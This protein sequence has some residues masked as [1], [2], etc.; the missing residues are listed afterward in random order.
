MK[1]FSVNQVKDLRAE[2]YL[3]SLVLNTPPGGKLPGINSLVQGSGVGRIRLEHVLAKLCA[4]GKLEVRPSS[5]YYRRAVSDEDKRLVLIDFEYN[6][7]LP[8]GKRKNLTT[9]AS[10]LQ[11][12][13]AELSRLCRLNG[14]ELVF[15]SLGNKLSGVD[16]FFKNNRFV[17]GFIR[18]SCC[19]EVTELF[20]KYLCCVDLLPQNADTPYPTVLDSLEM[21][22]IQMDYLLRRGYRHIGYLHQTRDSRMF[23]QNKRLCDYYRVMAENGI[24]VEPNWVMYCGSDYE[25]FSQ[26]LYKVMNSKRPPEAFIVDGNT[27]PAVYR[28]C[29]SNGIAVGRD[30]AIMGCDDLSPELKPR[31]TSV[32]NVP[33]EIAV[34]A[35]RVMDAALR[36]EKLIEHTNLKIVTG[37]SVPAKVQ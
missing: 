8:V 37:E 12:L 35:W 2:N 18:G 28:F 11:P 14:F 31:V 30:L 5:G 1:R 23:L 29:A 10:F 32:T 9:F 19:N 3:N 13:T 22:I 34:Q 17:G 7:A 6:F 27:I 33:G 21:T 4:A 26:N 15:L 20:S 36:G 25:V 24:A 16:E